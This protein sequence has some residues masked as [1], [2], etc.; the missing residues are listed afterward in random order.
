MK[1]GNV[2]VLAI[3]GVLVAGVLG[4]FIGR[5]SALAYRPAAFGRGVVMGARFGAHDRMMGRGF[6]RGAG[7]M[8][9]VSGAIT[10]IN[11]STVTVKMAD[12]TT[13]DMTLS[14]TAVVDTM[15]KGTKSDLKVGSSIMVYG[16]GFW[17]G[18]QTVIVKPQ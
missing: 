14:D 3:V 18:A 11:G 4:F 7:M 8:N 15:T 9:G 6:I 10:N 16:G 2:V 1:D 13:R 12:G 17:N 5:H